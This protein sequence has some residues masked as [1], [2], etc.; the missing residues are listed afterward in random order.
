M[1]SGLEVALHI[2][3]MFRHYASRLHGIAA[4][5]GFEDMAVVAH[6]ASAHFVGALGTGNHVANGFVDCVHHDVKDWVVRC[7][8]Q[9]AMEVHVELSAELT[10]AQYFFLCDHHGF[11][12]AQVFR[13]SAQRREHGDLR[14]KYGSDF[15]QVC[16]LGLAQLHDGVER[17]Q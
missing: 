10:I 1:V 12:L 11:D 9:L 2:H 8:S 14:L 15:G 7:G 6:H 4:A 16:T 3:N 5:H 17:I 13:G